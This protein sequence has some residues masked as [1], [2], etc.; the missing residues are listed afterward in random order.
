M[1][2]LLYYYIIILSSPASQHPASSPHAHLSLV[3]LVFGFGFVWA[4]G[5]CA[6]YTVDELYHM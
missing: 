3:R 4:V 5:R 2:K 6:E 1:S